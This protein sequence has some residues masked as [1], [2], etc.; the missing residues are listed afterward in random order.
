MIRSYLLQP[1]ISF[2][3]TLLLFFHIIILP[4]ATQDSS[5]T[6]SSTFTSSTSTATQPA[7]YIQ[8]AAFTPTELVAQ[9]C[10]QILFHDLT[11]DD[12]P[13]AFW[14]DCLRI[15]N[16][17]TANRG[18]YVWDNSG[19]VGPQWVLIRAEGSCAL[20]MR[21]RGHE[22]DAYF[23]SSDNGNASSVN[24]VA[25]V[26]NKD[27]SKIVY[28]AVVQFALRYGTDVVELWGNATCDQTR[29]PTPGGPQGGNDAVITWW[30]RNSSNLDMLNGELPPPDPLPPEPTETPSHGS[31]G[32][33]TGTGEGTWSWMWPWIGAEK[34]ASK[35]EPRACW[36]I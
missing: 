25:V 18:A 19:A 16:W 29:P 7:P 24:K 3:L 11:S 26:G 33:V 5:S 14:T 20:V 22:R 21:Y 13:Q 34:T 9:T 2:L 30:L 10:P 28:N 32:S 17:T 8:T 27:V 12:I 1:S 4:A 36:L 23:P 31:A 15:S 6:T 35:R